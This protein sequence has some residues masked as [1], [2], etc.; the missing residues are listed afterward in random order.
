MSSSTAFED[1]V[2]SAL[3]LAKRIARLLASAL[4]S[5]EQ[6]VR[7]ASPMVEFGVTAAVACL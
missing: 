1:E 5:P 2:S 7:S 4:R 6:R 3:P